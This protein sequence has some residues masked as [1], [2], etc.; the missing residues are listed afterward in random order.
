MKHTKKEHDNLHEIQD[1][2]NL[3]KTGGNKMP[4]ETKIKRSAYNRS[5]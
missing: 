1:L 4:E 3:K 5:R 2:G